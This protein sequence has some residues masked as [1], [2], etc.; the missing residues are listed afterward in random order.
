MTNPADTKGPDTRQ[1]KSNSATKTEDIHPLLDGLIQGNRKFAENEFSTDRGRYQTLAHAQSPRV[2]WIGC[3]D[4]RADPERIT[5]AQPGELFITRNFGNI[6]PVHDLSLSAV[7]EYSISHLKIKEI[8]VVGHSD[9]GAMK[10]LDKDHQD[11]YLTLWLND[12]REAKTRVDARISNAGTPEELK[13][14][15]HQIEVENI[16]LQIE[17]LMTYPSVGRAVDERTIQ[18]HGLY[19]DLKTGRLSRVV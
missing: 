9:C 14:R 12:A 4:S 5:G 2:L 15:A 19:Y 3:S 1:T 16:R 10:A 13:E 11:P 7:I 8:I 17:H 18:V 6:V